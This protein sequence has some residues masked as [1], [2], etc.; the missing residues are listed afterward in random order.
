MVLVTAV[1]VVGTL[2]E[3]GLESAEKRM[4]LKSTVVHDA[5]GTGCV[6]DSFD[7]TSLFAKDNS[8][9]AR[10]CLKF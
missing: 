7:P 9:V 5:V 10:L 6:E 3:E 4:A 1:T 8:L 2:G